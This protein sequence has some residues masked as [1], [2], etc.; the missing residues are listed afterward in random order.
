M[1]KEISA[2]GGLALAAAAGVILTSSPASA[3]VPTWKHRHHAHSRNVIHRD[4]K[5]DNVMIGTH[6]QVYVMDWGCAQLL[7]RARNDDEPPRSTGQPSVEGPG[8]EPEGTVS[9]VEPPV[10]DLSLLERFRDM[11]KLSRKDRETVITVIDALLTSREHE[12]VGA[13]RARRSA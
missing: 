4:L 6:G 3:Q 9:E 1:L 13:K 5:P 11:E 2:A 10:H 7:D 12:E 8:R